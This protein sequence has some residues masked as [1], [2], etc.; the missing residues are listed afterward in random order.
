VSPSNTQPG[1]PGLR[2]V[3]HLDLQKLRFDIRAGVRNQAI[4]WIAALFDEKGDLVV[5]RETELVFR[6][7]EAT[8]RRLADGFVG[9]LTLPAKPGHY[10]LRA[11]VQ[12]GLESKITASSQAVEIH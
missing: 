3:L 11:V 4:T 12:D 7:K 5:G 8:F 2:V 1:E 6:L 9:G 10:R